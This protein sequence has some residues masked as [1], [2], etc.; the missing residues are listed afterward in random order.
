[1]VQI[2]D[3][4]Q[5]VDLRKTDTPIN[6]DFTSTQTAMFNDMSKHGLFSFIMIFA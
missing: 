4:A 2:V 6:M 1:M 3:L 5:A